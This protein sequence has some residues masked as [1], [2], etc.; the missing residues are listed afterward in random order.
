MVF[1]YLNGANEL[2]KSYLEII[3]VH[4]YK[5]MIVTNPHQH[6]QKQDQVLQQPK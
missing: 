4:V 2:T 5:K 3:N 6:L 1:E